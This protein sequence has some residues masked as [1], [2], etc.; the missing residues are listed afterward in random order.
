MAAVRKTRISDLTMRVHPIPPGMRVA[1][2]ADLFLADACRDLL[3]LP[4]VQDGRPLGVISRYAIMRIFLRQYGRE[5]FGQRPIERFMNSAPLMVDID[6]DVEAASAWVRQHMVLPVTE[7]FIIVEQGHYRGMGMVTSLLELMEHHV[8]LRGRALARANA[9]LKASQAHLVQSEKMASLG[10]M[11]A[12]VA[13][14]IN[15]PLGYVRSN[16][17]LARDFVSQT[18]SAL[19]ASRNLIHCLLDERASDEEISGHLMTAAEETESVSQSGI[20]EEVS[21]LFDDTLHGLEQISDLVVNLRNFSRLDR[22]RVDH[23]NLN[24][25]LDSALTIGRNLIKHKAEVICDYGDLPSVECAASQINQVFL[26]ILTNAAQAIAD[27]GRITVR[28]RTLADRDQVEV[29][30]RDNGCGMPEEVRARI[31]DP[32]FT[33]KPVGQGTGL[34]LSI[35]YQ[36]IE[37]HRGS[38]DVVSTPGEG[39]EFVLCLPCRQTAS[40]AQNPVLAEAAGSEA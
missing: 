4:V 18:S 28:T 1:D 29:R 23:V 33:T 40:A 37:Q 7:D 16:V 9:S 5:I 32:F 25:S 15:T 20:L 38:I 35:S 24:E 10:Q 3:C 19:V 2:V 17:E 21:P 36:I 39:T 11:V 27:Y 8:A 13:H 6:A 34:G 22:A 31:F 12:G 26:N 30:I 14:E